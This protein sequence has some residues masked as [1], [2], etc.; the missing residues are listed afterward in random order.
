LVY[1][2][3]NYLPNPL[4]PEEFL[5][6]KIVI[7]RK[8]S[9]TAILK[10][11]KEI[12]EKTPASKRRSMDSFIPLDVGNNAP[13]EIDPRVDDALVPDAPA[14][15]ILSSKATENRLT[16]SPSL[17]P[18][19]VGY[20]LYRSLD[21]G[22]F[23]KQAKVVTADQESLFIDPAVPGTVAGYY[24]TSVN[25]VGKESIPSATVFTNGVSGPVTDNSGGSGAVIAPAPT[26]PIGISFQKN[27]VN[28]QIDW[29]PNPAEQQ[30]KQY[31]VYYSETEHGKYRKIGTAY[32]PQ[33]EYFSG[34]YNGY[35]SI[36][37]IN[38]TGESP[39]STP[40]TYASS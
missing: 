37:A 15:V 3:L 6:E 12:M 25:I 14:N 11:I 34:I 19:I 39:S 22:S 24:I 20:R 13:E 27:G 1:N 9:L 8:D 17:N 38:N 7:K 5:Q 26:A 35:Y 23:E 18:N 30:I 32:Q 31:D 16:F 40:I 2:K 29:T 21:N 10:Q 36:I 4:T 33:F 28:L